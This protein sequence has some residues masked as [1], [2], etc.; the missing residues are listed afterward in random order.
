MNFTF[1]GKANEVTEFWHIGFNQAIK[2]QEK[3]F[4]RSFAMKDGPFDY[5]HGYAEGNITAQHEWYRYW[6]DCLLNR[7]N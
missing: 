5:S 2:D 6:E 7:E 3:W 4:S 1:K